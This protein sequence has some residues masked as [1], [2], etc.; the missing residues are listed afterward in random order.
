MNMNEANEAAREENLD[1]VRAVTR[2]IDHL[3]ED[4]IELMLTDFLRE[5]RLIGRFLVWIEK[6][7][8]IHC[9]S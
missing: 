2:S 7:K 1:D 8:S 6:W 3:T 5:N 9:K 4:D